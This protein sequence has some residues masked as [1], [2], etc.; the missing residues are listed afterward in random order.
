V[1]AVVGQ[2]LD[3]L[4]R[5]GR[6]HRVARAE[7]PLQQ[8]E[9]P[10][11]EQQQ[12]GDR[13]GEVE[14]VRELGERDVAELRLGA[15]VGQC[16][17]VALPALHVRRA[18]EQ[19]AGLAEQ[20]ER[21][22]GQR[23]L[24]LQLRSVGHPLREPMAADQRVVTEHQ[25]VLREVGRVDAVRDGGGDLGLHVLHTGAERP[26]R[27]VLPHRLDQRLVGVG[28][29]VVARVVVAVHRCGT[30]SGIA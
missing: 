18:G 27:V 12:P 10:R 26:P 8:R 20:V 24:L 9:P 1:V 5:H 7:Q 21:G 19:H 23:D 2:L 4:A 15:Q 30:S 29:V 25:A 14:V 28:G 13:A 22:V 3:A 16:V 6:H 11:R 17:L